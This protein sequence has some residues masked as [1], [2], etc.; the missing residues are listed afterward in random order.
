MKSDRDNR[1]FWKVETDIEELAQGAELEVE[2]TYVIKND[3]D[4]DYLN[5]AL[6]GQYEGNI[7]EYS[8]YLLNIV[9]PEGENLKNNIKGKTTLKFAKP[10]RY[11][12][13][14]K[15]KIKL[16]NKQYSELRLQAR[17]PPLCRKL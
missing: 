11:I 7:D 12:G 3:S 15:D 9:K 8:R 16:N 13:R 4:E 6:I 1:N 17:H 2:Y 14:G 10:K 5:R